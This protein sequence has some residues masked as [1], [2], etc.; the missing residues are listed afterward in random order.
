VANSFEHSTGD[1]ILK[2]LLPQDI[3]LIDENEEDPDNYHDINIC[4]T[5]SP[6]EHSQ[7]V[8]IPDK[9]ARLP[10]HLIENMGC[11]ESSIFARSVV[12]HN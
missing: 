9:S 11:T 7:T 4:Y 2:P 1:D 3:L 6:I 12:Y 8:S 10:A 5:E